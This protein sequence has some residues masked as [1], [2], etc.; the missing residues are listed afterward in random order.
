MNVLLIWIGVPKHH[1]RRSRLAADFFVWKPTCLFAKILVFVNLVQTVIF[2]L[3]LKTSNRRGTKKH[4][5][6]L[7]NFVL[8][9]HLEPIGDQNDVLSLSIYGVYIYIWHI[10]YCTLNTATWRCTGS[11]HRRQGNLERHQQDNATIPNQMSKCALRKRLT[12]LWSKHQDS[13]LTNPDTNFIYRTERSNYES[14]Y[15]YKIHTTTKWYNFYMKKELNTDRTK[16]RNQIQTETK[17]RN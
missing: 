6:K 15:Q 17:H 4:A 13:W 10:W 16:H 11:S 8:N 9:S 2:Y 14:S 3:L 7:S 12:Q 1:L 5:E